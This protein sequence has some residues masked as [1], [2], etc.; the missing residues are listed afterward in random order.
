[1]DPLKQNFVVTTEPKATLST[2]QT[3]PKKL[4]TKRGLM[5]MPLNN[6]SNINMTITSKKENIR[7][8]VNQTNY[9]NMYFI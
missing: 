3:L 4:R 7:G 1:M 9:R 8:I 5:Y 6:I 2:N